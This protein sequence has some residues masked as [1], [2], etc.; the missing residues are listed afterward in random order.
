MNGNILWGCV[1]STVLTGGQQQLKG[2]F[3]VRLWAKCFSSLGLLFFVYER[4][5]LGS[6][7]RRVQPKSERGTVSSQPCLVG[8][9]QRFGFSV[10]AAISCDSPLLSVFYLCC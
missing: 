1:Q 4:R 6:M 2:W 10:T 5:E 8:H 7:S 9:G 3:S